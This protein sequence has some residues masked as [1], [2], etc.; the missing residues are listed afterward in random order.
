MIESDQEIIDYEPLEEEEESKENY[1]EDVVK[2]LDCD[3]CKKTFINAKALVSHQR[4]HRA[5]NCLH[6]EKK[7]LN[8][9]Q[10][11]LH[12]RAKHKEHYENFRL[13]YQNAAISIERL[14]NFNECSQ[15]S[16][17]LFLSF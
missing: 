11:K 2:I 12:V 4:F 3:I 8:S 10:L 14:Q 13:G 15:V 16:A 17:L 7:F 5:D 9:T 6:C 1:H